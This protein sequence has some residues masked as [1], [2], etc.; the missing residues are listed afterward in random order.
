MNAPFLQVLQ[1][2]HASVTLLH[3][4]KSNTNGSEGYDVTFKLV[5]C[6]F[7]DLGLD[8]WPSLLYEGKY[9]LHVKL[10]IIQ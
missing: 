2:S 1:K 4:I 9:D 7:S 10:V 5:G 8:W 3:T 6:H